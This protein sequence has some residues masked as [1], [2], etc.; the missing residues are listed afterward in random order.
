MARFRAEWQ[1]THFFC[2]IRAIGPLNVAAPVTG[3]WDRSGTP[4][5]SAKT[6]AA[7]VEIA[8]RPEKATLVGPFTAAGS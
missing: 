5:Q 2:K 1:C 6:P 4:L 7:S 8:G 3:S